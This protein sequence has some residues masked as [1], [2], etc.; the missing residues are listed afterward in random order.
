M[1]APAP[2]KWERDSAGDW[3]GFCGQ[4]LEIERRG[5][6]WWVWTLAHTLSS[7]GRC[8]RLRDAKALAECAAGLAGRR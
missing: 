3:H 4:P 8:R 1:T 6:R 7:S 5:S 2:V